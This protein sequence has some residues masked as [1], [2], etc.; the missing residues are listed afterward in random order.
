MTGK[1]KLLIG[2]GVFALAGSAGAVAVARNRERPVEVRLEAVGRRDLVATVTASGNIRARR[3]VDISSD[4]TARVAALAVREG[5]D[6]EQGDTLMRLDPAL[7]ESAEARAEAALS[8]AEAQAANQRAN[9]LRAQREYD[10][11]L[12]LQ[13]RDPVLVS[14]LQIDDAETNLEVASA[15]LQAAGFGVQQ[16]R[17]SLVEARDRHSRT[18]ITAPISGKVTRLNIEEGE[19][20]IIGTMNNPGSLLLTISDLSVVEV[21]VQVD[22][23]DVPELALGDSASILIDAFPGRTFTG[24]VTEI[25]NSAIRP[26]AST[27][28]SGQQS[29]VDF[30]VVIT[31]DHLPVLLRPDLSATADIVTDQRRQALSVPIIALTV[32]QKEGTPEDSARARRD[33]ADSGARLA[34]NEVEGVFVVRAEEVAFA[35][36]T[37]GIA[38]QDYFEVLSGLAEG[39]TVVAGPYQAIRALE[40]GDRVKPEEEEA[41]APGGG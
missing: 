8:Q 24:R 29:A 14:Q 13:A 15:N 30:E 39:D 20:V 5:Q 27:A 17:A 37:L 21:V 9:L 6:V 16:A 26:P 7:F 35:P 22:E 3:S 32:R 18:V 12:A 31:L 41:T 10:R 28:A 11:I 38:G 33:T 19:T 1:Q 34:E 36:V 2:I 25:G 40:N 23:T 4:V